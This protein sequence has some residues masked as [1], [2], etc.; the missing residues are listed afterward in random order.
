M[1]FRISSRSLKD[2]RLLDAL[3]FSNCLENK[4]K[5]HVTFLD[6]LSQVNELRKWDNWSNAVW[7]K[8]HSSQIIKFWLTHSMSLTEHILYKLHYYK[9]SKYIYEQFSTFYVR[10]IV[11]MEPRFKIWNFPL[12]PLFMKQI[13]ISSNFIHKRV[14]RQLRF[15]KNWPREFERDTKLS[16]L[17]V[18]NGNLNYNSSSKL[19]TIS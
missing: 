1:T 19:C 16:S 5:N 4:C 11:I 3:P 6:Q 13:P 18:N 9:I 7:Y 8:K 15:G 12:I 14:R 10:Y 17:H 2:Q